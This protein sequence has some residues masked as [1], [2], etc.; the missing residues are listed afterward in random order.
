[1]TTKL[2]LRLLT[3]DN[4][5][6]GWMEHEAAALGDGC[7]RAVRDILIPVDEVGTAAWVSIHWCDIHVETRIPI[8]LGLSVVKPGSNFAVFL[9]GDPMVRL[10]TPPV[11]LPAVTLKRSVSIGIPPGHLGHAGLQP[12]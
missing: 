10:G 2:V 6:L 7:L 12:G 5:L 9:A 3:A 1:M 4:K 11:G 8:P